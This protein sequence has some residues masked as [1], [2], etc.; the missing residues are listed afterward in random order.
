ML[1]PDGYN[2]RRRYP[3]LVLLIGLSSHYSDWSD[4]GQGE[5]ARIAKGFPGIIV[6]PEGGDGWYADW[7]NGGKRGSPRGRATSSTR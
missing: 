1:L 6:M 3:L 2:P 5:I 4:P 7:W